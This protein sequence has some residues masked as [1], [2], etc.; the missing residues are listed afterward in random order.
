MNLRMSIH[1]I[2]RIFRQWLQ[3][4]LLSL[5]VMISLILLLVFFLLVFRV[6][7]FEIADSMI[8]LLRW[9][10]PPGVPFSITWNMELL[11]IIAAVFGLAWVLLPT[12]QRWNGSRK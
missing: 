12:G 10:N 5:L 8:W 11:M 4:T 2:W 6:P 1:K 9:Q 3:V 7:S